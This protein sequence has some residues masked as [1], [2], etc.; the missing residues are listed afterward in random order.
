[1]C[2]HPWQN[3]SSENALDLRNLLRGSELKKPKPNQDTS[4]KQKSYWKTVFSNDF[5]SSHF[6]S[7][8]AICSAN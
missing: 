7:V 6:S 2:C 3:V 8:I 5:P 1:M 4:G